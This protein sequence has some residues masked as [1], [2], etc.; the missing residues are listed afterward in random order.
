MSSLEAGKKRVQ[1]GKLR[2]AFLQMALRHN[3]FQ[4][5]LVTPESHVRASWKP[6]NAPGKA[7]GDVSS[8]WAPCGHMGDP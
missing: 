3:R 5:P 6:A 4:L 1:S 8:P 7:A 2:K